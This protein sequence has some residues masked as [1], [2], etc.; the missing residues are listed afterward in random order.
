MP[1]VLHK[2]RNLT[3]VCHALVV[4]L[5]F[6]PYGDASAA[7]RHKKPMKSTKANHATAAKPAVRKP[8]QRP[9]KRSAQ[10]AAL[11]ASVKL[12]AKAAGIP[13]TA[14]GLAVQEVGADGF[15]LQHNAQQAFSP[16][17]TMK[18]VTSTAALQI[19]G[20]NYTWKTPVYG[21]GVLQGNTWQGD[22]IIKGSFDPKLVLENFWL[23]LR[24]LRAKGITHIHGNIL[25]DRSLAPNVTG[26]ADEF[27]AAAIKAY[28]VLPDPLL[29]NY[30][31]LRL[32]FTPDSSKKTVQ[33]SMEPPLPGWQ[34]GSLRLAEGV[35]DE[36][37][38]DMGLQLKPNSLNFTGTY[39]ASCGE[40]AWNIHPYT[41]DADSYFSAVFQSLW[42]ELG[43]T[44][45][46]Q[47]MPGSAP[48]GAPVLLEWESPQLAEVLRDI[49][50]F[51]N[52]VMARQLLL[53]L[54]IEQGRASYAQGASRIKTWLL[55]AGIKAD[56]LVID[57][58]SGLSRNE[59]IAPQTMAKL[60]QWAFDGPAMPE[61]MA[62]LPLVG[63]DG[64][65][66]NRLKNSSVAGHAH[67]KTG[68]LGDVRA[69]AGFVLASSGKR[70]VVV[71]FVNH[72]RALASRPVLDSLLEWVYLNG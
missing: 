29:L 23:L 46:G 31:T 13:L 57:N 39:A 24:Q 52:N 51:S 4:F 49:N 30:K 70:Y 65:M 48:I 59:R 35:C 14:L 17:S 54:G 7:K 3:I 9:S 43:G 56:E 71:G 2:M 18:L 27:D 5:A 72:P 16:A 1:S 40:R 61:L 8:L 45:D 68:T 44:F 53:T 25:L 10:A 36:W 60:L 15:L 62:S 11:P 69:V 64:T 58:G 50:K 33:V 67:I 21:N 28:N 6:S 63:V 41:M 38:N 26:D 19:L 20:P 66:R 22:L 47:V 55:Q 37:R 42:R 12:A 34:I 32:Q